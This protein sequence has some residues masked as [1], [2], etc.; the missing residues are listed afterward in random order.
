MVVNK[1]ATL[2]QSVYVSFSPPSAHPSGHKKL[3]LTLPL[4]DVRRP[5][6]G[7][8]YTDVYYT[9]H[10]GDPRPYQGAPIRRLEGKGRRAEDEGHRRTADRRWRSADGRKFLLLFSNTQF[11]QCCALHFLH[12]FRIIAKSQRPSVRFV[13]S[14]I[15]LVLRLIHLCTKRATLRKDSKN[16]GPY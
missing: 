13:S 14:T 4:S 5:T 11:F 9:P 6:W 3:Y 2:K 12:Y 8:S 15:F 1:R 16:S 7:Q 10:L